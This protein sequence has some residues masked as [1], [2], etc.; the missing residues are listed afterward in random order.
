M[1]IFTEIGFFSVV[2]HRHQPDCLLVRARART[3]LEALIQWIP[4]WVGHDRTCKIRIRSTPSADYPFRCIV[5]RE[6]FGKALTAIATRIHYDNF[7]NRVAQTQ[8][9]ERAHVYLV[10]WDHLRRMLYR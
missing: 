2:E 5:K 8:G 9:K 4:R 6:A 3:D 10:V 1:W 7:K